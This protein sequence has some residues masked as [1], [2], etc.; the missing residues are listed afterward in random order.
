MSIAMLYPNLTACANTQKQHISQ[1]GTTC[2]AFYIIFAAVPQLLFIGRS[3][4]LDVINCKC[5]DNALSYE[6]HRDNH[7]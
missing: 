6:I 1:S 4:C 2:A 5:L 3:L 7:K